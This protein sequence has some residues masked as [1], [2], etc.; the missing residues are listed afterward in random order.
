MR[1]IL[2]T[3][4]NKGIGLAIASA[5][6]DEHDDTFVLL[7]SRVAARG[8][9][10]IDQLVREHP[11][12][13]NRVA[14]IE[15]DVASDASVATA[16]KEVGDHYGRIPQP[17]HAVVNN[18]GVGFPADDVAAVLNVNILGVRRVCEAFLPLLDPKAGR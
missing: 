8:R 2:V 6:L 9:A 3:G 1:R 11:A 12:W 13:A 5:I 14:L 4:A 18:A 16:A 15:L 7:G 17:L 10:A